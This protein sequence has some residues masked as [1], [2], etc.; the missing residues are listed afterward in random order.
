MKSLLVIAM[1][2]FACSG[3]TDI[4]PPHSPNDTAANTTANYDYKGDITRDGGSDCWYY[5]P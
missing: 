3:C 2:A 1:V 4:A 5:C